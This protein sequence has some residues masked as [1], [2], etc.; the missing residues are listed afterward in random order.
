MKTSSRGGEKKTGKEHGQ[1]AHRIANTDGV[2]E[3]LNCLVILVN[4]DKQKQQLYSTF[5]LSDFQRG[6]QLDGW[7]GGCHCG[8]MPMRSINRDK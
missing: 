4:R 1:T 7:M 6:E 3:L 8:K 5:H 2:Y